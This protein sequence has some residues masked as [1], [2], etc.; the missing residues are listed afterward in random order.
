MR[1]V[2]LLGPYAQRLWPLV[3]V[4]RLMRLANIEHLQGA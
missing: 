2:L 4:R 3:R 1:A